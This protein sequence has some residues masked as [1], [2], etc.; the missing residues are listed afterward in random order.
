MQEL[1]TL[2]TKD[3]KNKLSLLYKSSSVTQ[4]PKEKCL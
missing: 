3:E 4:I 2:L 1:N